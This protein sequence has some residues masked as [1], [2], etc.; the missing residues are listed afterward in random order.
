MQERKWSSRRFGMI[1]MGCGLWSTNYPLHKSSGWVTV[2][3]AGYFYGSGIW[4]GALAC[5]S[6]MSVRDHDNKKQI[7]RPYSFLYRK[8]LTQMIGQPGNDTNTIQSKT[9]EIK[10]YLR[11]SQIPI[12]LQRL[13]F[14]LSPSCAPTTTRQ[15]RVSITP[16]P[17]NPACVTSPRSKKLQS[18]HSNPPRERD[19]T[20]STYGC[21]E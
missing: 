1:S 21:L 12:Q 9:Q 3:V 7:C 13:D 2:G 17:A 16:M 4:Q 5:V 15:H 11:S 10:D 14:D 18:K 6:I 20:T 19:P 8:I